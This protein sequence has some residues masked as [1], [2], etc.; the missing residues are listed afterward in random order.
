MTVK[1]VILLA[2]VVFTL[3]ALPATASALVRGGSG[4]VTPFKVGSLSIGTATDGQM[5][6]SAGQPTERTYCGSACPSGKFKTYFYRFP[7]HGL[8]TYT[9]ALTGG[10]WHLEG[11][12]TNQKS[13][14]TKAGTKVGMTVAEANQ[15]EHVR[16]HSGCMAAGLKRSV[17]AGGQTYTSIVS[18]KKSGNA[19]V[20]SLVVVGPKD[21]PCM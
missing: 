6:D 10:A 8:T 7:N 14:H 16:W 12:Y 15:R 19:K 17:K 9:F 5:I 11:F 2:G 1:R 21:E 18:V 3:A 20:R 13:F 4:L